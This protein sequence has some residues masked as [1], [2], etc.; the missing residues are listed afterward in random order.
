MK[1]VIVTKLP[2]CDICAMEGKTEP[3][4]YD[5][6]VPGEGW[7]NLC[8]CHYDMHGCSLGPGKAQKLVLKCPEPQPRKDRADKL[9][10]YCGKSCPSDGWNMTTAR[11]RILDN[12][13]EI[14]VMVSAGLYCE[15][16]NQ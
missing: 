3:A 14:D 4:K 5:T 15:E 9:C 16:I 1:T 7:M 12:P 10:E 11:F 8:Q 6:R 2:N 13:I